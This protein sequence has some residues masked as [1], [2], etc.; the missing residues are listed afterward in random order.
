VED[1]M[2][3]L[4]SIRYNK[5]STERHEELKNRTAIGLVLSDYATMAFV[6]MSVAF[7]PTLVWLLVWMASR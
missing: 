6:F 2:S 5:D 1:I 7:G 4:V 3:D